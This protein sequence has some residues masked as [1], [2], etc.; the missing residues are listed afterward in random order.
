MIRFFFKMNF[1]LNFDAFTEMTQG[2]K[3]CFGCVLL[4]TIS[5]GSKDY[6]ITALTLRSNRSLA[7]SHEWILMARGSRHIIAESKSKQ[8]LSQL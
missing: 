5:E 2:L 7:E 6:D 8:V 3:L 1:N 4:H